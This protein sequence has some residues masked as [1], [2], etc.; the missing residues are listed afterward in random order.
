MIKHIYKIYIKKIVFILVVLGMYL[1]LPSVKSFV[2]QVVFYLSMDNIYA[3]NG[4]IAS[5]ES[6]SYVMSMILMVFQA[7]L[8]PLSSTAIMQTNTN[9][10]GMGIGVV[11]S[12]IGL[13]AGSTVCFLL[14]KFLL[15]DFI[16]FLS[17]KFKLEKIGDFV[18]KNGDGIVL[19][20][21][22]LIIL[23]FD[24][25][26]YILGLTSISFKSYIRSTALG[27]VPYLAMYSYFGANLTYSIKYSIY[28][29]C[30]LIALSILIILLKRVRDISK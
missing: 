5:F 3:M 29:A 1:L 21:R 15:G 23:P 17:G 12:W 20:S 25:I 7:V 24:V 19:L 30:I 22:M 26:S 16:R 4:Y 11:V 2:N 27:C 10:Y 13:L 6:T 8:I 9:V 14:A 28:G 18:L